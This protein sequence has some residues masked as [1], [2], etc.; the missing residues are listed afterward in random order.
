MCTCE[1]STVRVAYN[2]VELQTEKKVG[3]Q[4]ELP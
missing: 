3:K 4:N 1:F 2:G